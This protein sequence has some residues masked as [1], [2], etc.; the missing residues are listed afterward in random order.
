MNWCPGNASFT[1]SYRRDDSIGVILKPPPGARHDSIH[2]RRDDG[3]R[4]AL[5]EEGSQLGLDALLH[6]VG[7][8]PA[9]RGEQLDAVVR[10]HVVRGGDHGPG[11]RL[12]RGQMQPYERKRQGPLAGMAGSRL[13]GFPL[14]LLRGDGRGL[15]FVT[16][17]GELITADGTLVVGPRSAVIG[18]DHQKPLA[19]KRQKSHK[20]RKPK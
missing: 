12:G 20:K 10:V 5:A 11:N 6:V 14:R 18:I 13:S 16:S 9:A 4:P 7:E 15:E 17:D 3:P 1:F 19:T 2:D 8:L